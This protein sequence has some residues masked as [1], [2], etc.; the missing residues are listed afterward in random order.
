M[1]ILG[2]N[3]AYHE[4]S[5][6]LIKDGKLIAAIEEER[7]NRIKYAKEARIDNPDELPVN[8]INFCLKT[9]GIKLKDVDYI[10]YS[11]NPEKRLKNIGLNEKVVEG[12]WGSE[13]GEKLFYR[14]LKEI[15][16]RLSELAG[17]D[18]S[19]RFFWI[20]HHLCH[21]GSSYFVS[22]F[23]E[24]AIISID[25][26][27]EFTTAWIGYGKGNEIKI[28]C[29]IEYPNSLGFLWEKISEFLG[30]GKHDA[31]KVMGLAGYGN[32]KTC[33]KKFR[34]FVKI[35]NGYFLMDNNILN[36]RSN[37]F[38]ELE[39]I[40]GPARK[41][42]SPMTKRYMDIAAALQ[43]IK[44]E[45]MVNIANW[46]YE[47]TKSKNICLAGGVAL[48]CLANSKI[49]EKTKFKNMYIHPAAHDGGTAIGA[50]FYIWNQMLGKPKT[51][52][53]GSPYTGPEFSERETREILEKNKIIFSYV[54]N[55]EKIVAGLIAEGSIVGWFQGK[56]EFGPR[57]LGNRSLLADPRNP[58]MKDILNGRIK[59]RE[60]F[61]PFATRVLEDK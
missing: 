3:S 44:E 21:A 16:K 58:K 5:A 52:V 29:E 60:W 49:L 22:S 47:K 56:T 6:C 26:I 8:A 55:I 33:I 18:I 9:V 54:R 15:P 43:I 41:N 25:G 45:I 2:I 30:F 48:N 14:K 7:L 27:G 19:K 32:P 50:A 35:K 31:G 61:R 20:D 39:K 46:V 12:G 11:F 24:S 34:K 28:I 4:S 36:F 53:M 10:G 38:S 37:D 59:H 40:L 51:Y 42:G 23:K 13:E 1:I 17:T 57:A